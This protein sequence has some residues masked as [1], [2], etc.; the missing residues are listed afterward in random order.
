M[1]DLLT[2]AE[3]CKRLKI[4]VMTVYRWRQEGMPHIK[5]GKVVRFEWDKV[6]NWLEQRTQ[7]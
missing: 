4:S 3:L 7:K 5:Q 1:D 2:Q 6:Q